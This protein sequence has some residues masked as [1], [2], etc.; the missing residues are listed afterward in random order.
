M[1]RVVDEVLDAWAEDDARR[2]LLIR[3]ARQVGKTYAVAALAGRRFDDFAAINLEQEPRYR[4]CFDTLTPQA[5][6]DQVGVLRGKPIEPGRTLL[7]LDEIQEC[8]AA[9]MAL[10]YFYEQAPGLHVIGAGSLLEF[11]LEAERLRMPVGRIQPLFMHPLSFAEFLPAVGEEPALQAARN[12][13]AVS[14]AVHEHLTGLLRTYL[15][16]GGMPAVLAEYRRSGSVM[17]ATRVQTSVTQTLRDDFGKY[18]R[19]SRHQHLD[20]VFLHAA[21]LVGRK[22]VYAKV[23]PDSR[24]RELRAAVELLERA[25]LVRR[26]RST[27]GAGLPLGAEADDQHYKLLMLDVGLMQNLSGATEQLLDGDPM[28]VDDGAVAEQFAGQELLAHRSP[29]QRP[30]LFYWHRRQRN[31]SAEVD[32]LVAAHGRVV[33]VEIK[34]G[35]T[36]R[37]RS[38]A[39]FAEHYRPPVAVRVYGDRFRRDGSIASLPLYGMEGLPAFLAQAFDESRGQRIDQG[40]NP[41]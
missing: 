25:G 20:R 29:Y 16:L 1:W 4:R 6:L 3:G 33:P 12:V 34:A 36:G 9:I 17:R 2:P 19:A 35:K 24:A 15:L 22:F 5:I 27:S 14:A 7:F 38:L 40:I 31:S 28:R 30:E 26:V 41:V 37:L 23:D 39:V 10:R 21:R 32:Y 18:A 8:P 13:A 11:A